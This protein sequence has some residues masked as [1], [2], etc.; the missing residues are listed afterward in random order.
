MRFIATPFGEVL[1]ILKV[2]FL[3][4]TCFITQFVLTA[5]PF[6]EDLQFLKICPLSCIEHNE[7]AILK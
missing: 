3:V 7:T 4:R 6:Q 5:T 2:C 1:F